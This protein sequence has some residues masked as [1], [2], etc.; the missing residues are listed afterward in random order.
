M[1]IFKDQAQF[2]LPCL[3][4]C[5]QTVPVCGSYQE[6]LVGL[7]LPAVAQAVS[8][9]QNGL[10]QNEAL[11]SVMPQLLQVTLLCSFQ[12][13]VL[14]FALLEQK[15]NAKISL[16]FSA[17]IAGASRGSS[18]EY[19]TLCVLSLQWMSACQQLMAVILSRPK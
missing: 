12:M 1:S 15:R 19:D 8:A 11:S 10:T 3:Q 13:C 14:R 2:A 6:N 17:I 18:P 9:E 16:C 4:W 5:A 7:L